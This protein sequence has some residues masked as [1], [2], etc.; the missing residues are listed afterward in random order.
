MNQFYNIKGDFRGAISAAIISLPMS[1]GYGI[2]AFAPLGIDFIPYAAIIGLHAAIIGGFFAALF[3]GTP[4][5]IS[6]PKAPLTL[7]L[8]TVVAGLAASS[9]IPTT[10]VH[11]QMLIVALASF[12]VLVGGISQLIF[13]YFRMG[14]IVKCIPYP[15]VAGFMNGIALLLIWKQLPILLGIANDVG[16]GDIFLDFNLVDRL[17]LMAG[18]FTMAAILLAKRHLKSIPSSLIGIIIGTAAYHLIVFKTNAI[19]PVQTLSHINAGIP[20]PTIFGEIAGQ[21]TQ[22]R[23]STI[24]PDLIGYGI[25]IGFIGS[26]ES[27]LSSVAI[28]NRTATRHDSNKEL[29]GQGV[30]NIAASFFGALPSAGSI[31]RS[32]ASYQCGGRTRLA[33][34]LCSCFVLAIML[35]MGPVISRIPLAVFAGVIIC[36]GFYLFD[37]W[38]LQLLRTLRHPTKLKHDVLIDLFVVLCVAIT[39]V[40]VS[41]ISAVFVGVAISF[42]YFVVKMGNSTISRE[43]LADHIHS[44]KKRSAGEIDFLDR[45]GH[46]IIVFELQGALFFGSANRLADDIEQKATCATYCILDMQRVSEIDS[47]AAKLLIQIHNRFRKE[48]KRLFISHINERHEKWEFLEVMGVVDELSRNSFHATTDKAL[49]WAEDRLLEDQYQLNMAKAHDPAGL[50]ILKGI[51]PPELKILKNAM[52]CQCLHKVH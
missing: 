17:S 9:E 26:I 44:M 37:S 36:V 8:A 49:Q 16:L 13:G 2:T 4:F 48:N 50:D 41:P 7:L 51:Q 28:D 5:Q 23:L 20:L 19:D 18:C 39:T 40:T 12:C 34:M 43:Y 42:A 25:V 27:L 52:H 32:F 38:T 35:T 21:V 46:R 22:L 45:E 6:G 11:R 24:L 14:S 29:M 3:G 1:I 47:T 31:P 15:V 33:G 10:V 30:G